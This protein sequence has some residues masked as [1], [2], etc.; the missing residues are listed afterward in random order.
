MSTLFEPGTVGRLKLRN[1]IMRS[2]TAERMAHPESGRPLSGQ[3]DMYTALAQGGVGLI[4][5]GHAYIERT[6]KAHPEMASIASDD[7][8]PAWR[9]VIRPAQEEGARL[10]MQINHGGASCDST[11]TP[12]PL[13]PSGVITE[14]SVTP[15]I[16]SEEDTRRIVQD[17][18]QAARRVREA[19]FDGVQIHGAHGY[20]VTQFLT[21]M[22]NLRDDAWGG[23]AERRLAFLKAIVQEARRQVGDDYPLWVKLGVAGHEKSQLTSD[24]G[25]R[26]AA[27]CVGYGVDCIE[28]SHA[29]GEPKDIDKRQEAPYRP[30]AEAVRQAVGNDFPLA[31]VNG[32]RTRVGM[33][34][35]LDGDLVQ[36]VSLCRPLIVEPD[37]PDKLR[38]NSNYKH[39][40]TRCWECWPKELGMGVAC[41]SAGVLRRLERS[42]SGEKG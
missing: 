26:I 7:V 6:G 41:R 1:R 30:W 19:G 15:R 22:T 40:C 18:G 21:P 34:A 32:F 36:M 28:I 16:M 35:M 4:V 23:D 31:L 12:Q 14:K 11:V 3:R 25:A 8:I 2:A 38:E 33:E 17:F 5:T 27:A 10:M 13:S 20:L 29:L 9:E 42:T 24:E 39:V 37:L